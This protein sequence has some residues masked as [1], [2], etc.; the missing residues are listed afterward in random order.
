MNEQWRNVLNSKNIFSVIEFA[1]RAVKNL[2]GY[3]CCRGLNI[4]ALLPAGM[5]SILSAS[6][7]T[8]E[9]EFPVVANFIPPSSAPIT[10]LLCLPLQ[11]YP[12]IF[13]LRHI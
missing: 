11:L 6:W 5:K 10:S 9:Q 2:H 4:K 12:N 7:K 1:Y 3:R 13:S 8:H